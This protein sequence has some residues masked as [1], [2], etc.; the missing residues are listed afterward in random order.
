MLSQK[1]TFWR[2]ALSPSSGLVMMME[3]EL[4]SKTSVF[5]STLMQLIAQED[6]ITF[7]HHESF[8]SFNT[9]YFKKNL[10]K[11]RHFC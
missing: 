8:K 6:F 2:L 9:V 7:M 1:P 5:D 3:T 4:V 10:A 11:N